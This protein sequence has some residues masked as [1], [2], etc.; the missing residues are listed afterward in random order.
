MCA[1]VIVEKWLE[2]YREPKEDKDIIMGV[3][4]RW[5]RVG[6]VKELQRK[7]Q[8][9]ILEGLEFKGWKDSE[10]VIANNSKQR[11]LL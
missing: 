10:G 3:E 8:E 1:I 4:G 6:G 5:S 7:G 11:H 9:P 2:A